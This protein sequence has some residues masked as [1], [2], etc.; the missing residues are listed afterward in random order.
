[1]NSP[2]TSAGVTSRHGLRSRLE[3][4]DL[5]LRGEPAERVQHRDQHRHRQGQRNR[6]RDRQKEELPDDRRREALSDEL[7]ELTR[8]EIEDHQGCQRRESKQKRADVF[9]DDVSA[10]NLHE[11]VRGAL[12]A[13]NFK[14]GTGL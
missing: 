13:R 6:E 8:D 3:C 2:A 5:V 7:A 12:R 11:A 1:M 4:G 14:I 9:P 10:D